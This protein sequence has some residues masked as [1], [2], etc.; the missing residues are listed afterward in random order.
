MIY[1]MCVK[2]NKTEIVNR[3]WKK[4]IKNAKYKI[5][6]WICWH[7]IQTLCWKGHVLPLSKMNAFSY[8]FLALV[9]TIIRYKIIKN[10]NSH[11]IFIGHTIYGGT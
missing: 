10:K 5:Q 4:V 11:N 2:S 1:K 7:I 6:N 9:T 3:I 8:K